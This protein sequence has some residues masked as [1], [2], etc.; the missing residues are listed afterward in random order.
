MSLNSHISNAIKR[1][2]PR[3]QWS[4]EEIDT[5]LAT[6]D[7]LDVSPNWEKSPA[8]RNVIPTHPLQKVYITFKEWLALVHF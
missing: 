7:M 5:A 8:L 4:Q 6:V 3:H 2:F 1:S